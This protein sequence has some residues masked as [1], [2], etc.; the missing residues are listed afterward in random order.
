MTIHELKSDTFDAFV[1]ATPGLLVLDF[2][3]P[4]CA[5]CR[6]L[7]ELLE[8]MEGEFGAPVTF[9]KLNVDDD[10][11]R[12]VAMGVRGVPTLVF[13]REGREVGRI[14]GMETPSVLRERIRRFAAPPAES[15]ETD[16]APRD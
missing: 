11:A 15:G 13:L 7:L 12:A 9:A 6:V 10:P 4:W 14:V 2:W 5:P 8:R 1:A 16:A 3:A